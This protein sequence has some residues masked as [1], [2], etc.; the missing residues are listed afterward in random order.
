MAFW[1]A[2]IADTQHARHAVLAALDMVAEMRALQPAFRER[3]WPAI[4]IGVGISSGEMNVGNMGSR[5]RAAYTVLGDTVNLGSR[6]EGLTKAYG[7]SIVVSEQTAKLAGDLPFRELDRVRV[8]GKQEPVAIF[9][10]IA[11]REA[12]AAARFADAL[13]RYRARDWDGAE[14]VVTE[15]DADAPQSLYQLYLGRIRHFRKQPPPSDWDGVFTF[16]VK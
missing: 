15:L 1:G 8:K 14:T 6:L 7:V 13:A 12:P 11:A 10:P 4:E 3:G 16:D 2:P 5:F 9:E